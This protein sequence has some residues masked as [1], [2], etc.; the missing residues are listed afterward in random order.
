MAR[1]LLAQDSMHSTLDRIVAHAVHLVNGCDAAGIMVVEGDRVRTVAATDDIVRVSN[2]IQ[3]EVGEG[4]CFDATRNQRE[5]YRIADLSTQE[6]QWTRYVPKA[7]KLGIGSM[8]GFLLYTH[9][10]S[11]LGALDLYGAKDGVFTEQSEQV[12]WLLASHAA[13]AMATAERVG[14]LKFGLQTRTLI[15]E[16]IGII[17]VRHRLT[18]DEAFARLTKASQNSNTKLRDLAE[19]VVYTGDLPDEL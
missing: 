7:R 11:N 4:P 16:A 2:H 14:N 9:D 5:V 6:L 1:D 15:G 19:T 17:M 12:G 8:M 3:G 18:D 10:R 13:V